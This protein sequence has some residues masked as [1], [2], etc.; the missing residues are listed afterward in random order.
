VDEPAIERSVIRLYLSI[1]NALSVQEHMAKRDFGPWKIVRELPP[2]G[3]AHTYVVVREDGSDPTQYV[4]KSLKNTGNPDR[5][6]RFR[7]EV[8]ILQGF[9]H[10]NIVKVL[11]DNLDAKRPYFVMEY[12]ANGSV[13]DHRD[14]WAD[15]IPRT[16]RLIADV[17]D[18]LF[19]A[20]TVKPNYIV[21]RDIKPSNIL[22]RADWTP[23]V[24]DFGLAYILNE[25]RLTETSEAVGARLFMPPEWT[26]GRT[27]KIW[28]QG[29]IY[30]VGKVLFA[31]LNRGPVFDRERHRHPDWNLVKKTKNPQLERVNR[32]LDRMIA[33][34]PED[35]YAVAYEP[36]REARDI[37]YLI[38][39][40]Y[41]VVSDKLL[42]RCTFCGLGVYIKVPSNTPNEVEAFGFRPVNAKWR[43]M[44]CNHCGHIQLF[45]LDKTADPAV[46]DR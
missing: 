27:D 30:G 38:E 20:H 39:K 32:L 31:M 23:V 9:N 1:P 11:H 12:C 18:A 40:D 6:A 16:L 35:R 25:E 21:H 33:E 13:Y 10:P 22:L 26:E 4:L 28:P 19:R 42:S 5:V 46:W 3:Q 17:L 15:D 34:D 44:A 24:A 7:R 8:G 14:R 36:A 41:R 2:S 37:A 45:R 29:D 43:I